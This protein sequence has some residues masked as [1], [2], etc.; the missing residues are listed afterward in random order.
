M[1]L[2]PSHSFEAIEACE[3]VSSEGRPRALG[4]KFRYVGYMPEKV[5]KF[6]RYG[7][8]VVDVGW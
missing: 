1:R 8:S 6:R 5:V 7:T 2:A 3:G 4:A